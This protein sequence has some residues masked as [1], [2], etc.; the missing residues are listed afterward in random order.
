MFLYA[1][2]QLLY[3]DNQQGFIIFEFFQNISCS[4]K[5]FLSFTLK[6][7]YV[8]ILVKE[9]SKKLKQKYGEKM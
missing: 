2:K 4:V 5:S 3:N 8:R 7:H 1:I 6:F 9:N